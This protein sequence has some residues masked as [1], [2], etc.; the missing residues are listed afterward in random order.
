[1]SATSEKVVATAE[2]PG[3]LE[4]MIF[5]LL[6]CRPPEAPVTFE[7]MM[8]YGFVHFD[9]EDPEALVSLS[10]VIVPWVDANFESLSEGY[11]IAAM[12][13]EDL[14]ES[15]VGSATNNEILGVAVG[16]DYTAGSITRFSEAMT[17][18]AQE[19]VFSHF[20]EFERE[21]LEGADCFSPTDCARFTADDSLHAEIALGIEYW[22]DYEISLRWLDVP[23]QGTV[24]LHQLNG[25]NPTDFSV[26]FIS[27]YQ[28][29]GFSFVYNN[30]DGQARRVQALWA[31]GDLPSTEGGYLSLGIT[32]MKTAN[33]DINTWMLGE[34][35]EPAP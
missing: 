13:S 2:S 29:Y 15:G 6:A 8:V 22:S 21:V 5:L 31:D 3:Q 24:L 16:V 33:G 4:I 28:Q 26:N 19:E 17:W 32:T 7:E 14:E 34:D 20:V 12:T 30:D 27:V 25:P 9:D 10:E 23:G 35:T 1:M 11:E 18:D